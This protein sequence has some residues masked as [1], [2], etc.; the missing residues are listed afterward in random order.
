MA[1]TSKLGLDLMPNSKNTEFREYRNYSRNTKVENWYLATERHEE[2]ANILILPKY[3]VHPIQ[4]QVEH[5]VLWGIACVLAGGI[6]AHGQQRSAHSTVT[7]H[8]MLMLVGRFSDGCLFRFICTCSAQLSKVA[9]CQWPACWCLGFAP[10]DGYDSLATGLKTKWR[11]SV[12]SYL[13]QIA[14]HFYSA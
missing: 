9:A 4:G 1:G 3:L 6:L 12:C 2:N 8:T 10:K 5:P 11:L 14:Q 7:K 13:L